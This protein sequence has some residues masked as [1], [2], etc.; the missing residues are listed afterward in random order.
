[1]TYL[2][3][4]AIAVAAYYGYSAYKRELEWDASI[5]RLMLDQAVFRELEDELSEERR[6]VHELGRKLKK[7]LNAARQLNADQKELLN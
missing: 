5:R 6:K 4:L 2:L 7:E 3:I 1:M